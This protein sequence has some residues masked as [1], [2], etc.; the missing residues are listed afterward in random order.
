[1]AKNLDEL[2]DELYETFN[3]ARKKVAENIDL[4]IYSY[5]KNAEIAM[6]GVE[7]AAKVAHAIVQVERELSEREEKK[8][9]MKLPGKG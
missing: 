4:N 3:D 2:K 5:P 8:S 9:G 6:Q 7:A 1:M